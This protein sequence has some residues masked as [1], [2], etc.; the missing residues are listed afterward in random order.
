M[1]FD[2]RNVASRSFMRW[3]SVGEVGLSANP[4][5]KYAYE[6]VWRRLEDRFGNPTAL[7]RKVQNESQ[8]PLI[9]D[10][11]GKELTILRDRMF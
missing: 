8:G 4:D 3:R 5:K 9:R 10:W 6:M 7:I 2:I 1:H 11:D